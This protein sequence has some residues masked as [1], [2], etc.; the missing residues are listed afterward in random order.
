MFEAYLLTHFMYRTPGPDLE[1]IQFSVSTDGLNWELLNDGAPIL[2]NHGNFGGLRDPFPYRKQDG[3]FIILAT[4]LNIELLCNDWNCAKT[5]GSQDL[6]LFESSDLLR[7]SPP[8]AVRM[9][10]V[11]ATCA[12]APEII[13]DNG[14]PLVIWSAKRPGERMRVYAAHTENFVDYG[15]PFIFV[16][17]D[18]DAIDTTVCLHEG[19]YYRFTKYDSAQTV[20]ME[21]AIS[22]HDPWTPVPGY[23][24]LSQ[25][26][27]EGPICSILPTGQALL[28]LDAYGAGAGKSSYRAFLSDDLHS[29]IF[30]PADDVFH[31]ACRMKHGSIMPITRLEY[32]RLKQTFS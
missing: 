23:T 13:D 31:S 16:N 21:Q 12:W 24:L 30:R 15:E 9:P 8:R 28:L 10:I 2:E 11:D 14:V 26:G 25:R 32:E 18:E 3:S 4:D 27:V 17:C 29:G 7:W 1:Q 20:V 19:V 5:A 22:L 6:I